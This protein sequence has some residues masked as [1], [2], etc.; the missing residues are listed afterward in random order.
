MAEQRKP[1]IRFW[2]LTD[3]T[4]LWAILGHYRRGQRG[5][6]PCQPHILIGGS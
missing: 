5:R 3:D 2:T 4:G 6:G 1:N